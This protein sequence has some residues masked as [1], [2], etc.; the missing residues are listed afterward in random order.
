MV[1][2]MVFPRYESYKDSGSDWLGPIPSDWK[3]QRLATV[4]EERKEKVSDKDFPPLSVTKNGVVTQL[5]SAAKSD[6]GDNRKGVR[7]GDFVINSRSDRKGSSGIA[8][9]DGSVSLINIVL[10][11]KGIAPRYSE[12]LLKSTGFIEEFYRNGHGIVA[13]L[14]TTRYWDMKSINI[15]LPDLATQ[16]CIANFLNHKTVEIDEAIAKKQHLIAMLKEQKAILINQAVTKGLNP[17][18]SMRDSGVDWICEVPAHWNGKKAKFLFIQSRLPV[19]KK[20]DVVTAYRDGQVTLRS[21]RR[22]EGYT[23]AILE[24]GYQGIRKGQLVLNSMDAFAGA[25]GVS[26]SDGKCSPEYVICDP[27]DREEVVPMYYAL[28]LREMALSG[29]IEVISSAVRQRAMRIRFSNLASL[30]LPVPPLTEQT[31]IVERVADLKGKFDAVMDILNREI[32]AI[33]EY[34]A[35]L[36][37]NTVTGKIKI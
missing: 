35:I 11:P 13:D 27:I 17:F 29:Y 26:D 10:K 3:L 28:L 19:Q 36:I 2:Q 15:P 16:D 4:F 31:E 9:Q 34:R 5:D 20:D 12:H 37:A 30:L 33:N 6:D 24:Q 22:T 8:K 7:E 1:Q 18:V 25:I 32:E 14:W 21:N 23:I